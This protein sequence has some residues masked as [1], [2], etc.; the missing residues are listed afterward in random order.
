MMDRMI[1]NRR[2]LTTSLIHLAS[3]RPPKSTR[4]ELTFTAYEM[5]VFNNET[6]VSVINLAIPPQTF[7]VDP[8]SGK[9]LLIHKLSLIS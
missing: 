6:H 7:H 4:C 8:E 5:Q 1:Q 2:H 3:K 9:G